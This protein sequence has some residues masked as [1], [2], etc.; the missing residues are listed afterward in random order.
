MADESKR[1]VHATSSRKL[2]KLEEK[3]WFDLDKDTNLYDLR[4][5]LVTFRENSLEMKE[6]N[7]NVHVRILTRF[8]VPTSADTVLEQLPSITKKLKK[9]NIGWSKLLTRLQFKR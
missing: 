7:I 4:E 8:D 9:E 3:S 1:A 2:V 6:A 5:L